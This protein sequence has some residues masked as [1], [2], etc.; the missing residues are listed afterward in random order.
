MN[1]LEK[2]YREVTDMRWISVV[3]IIAALLA[4]CSFAVGQSS[5][6][7]NL[8]EAVE[9]VKYAVIAEVVEVQEFTG[10][11]PWQIVKYKLVESLKG[12]FKEKELKRARKKEDKEKAKEFELVYIQ[13][14]KGSDGYGLPL[15]DEFVKKGEKFVLFFDTFKD[16]DGSEKLRSVTPDPATVELSATKEFLKQV[17]ELL[18]EYEKGEKEREKAL[19]KKSHVN[20][21]PFFKITKAGDDWLIIDLEEVKKKEL[22]VQPTPQAK[23]SVKRYYEGMYCKMFNKKAKAY[24]VIYSKKHETKAKIDDMKKFAE[25]DIKKRFGDN[26]TITSCKKVGIC[27]EPSWAFKYETKTPDGKL[28]MYRERYVTIRK[29]HIFDIWMWCPD[30]FSKEIKK[31]FKEMMKKFRF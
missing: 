29:G 17:K 30:E 9:F 19:K 11:V 28:K 15:P 5:G 22:A 27:R 3:L 16:K 13:S 23:E 14:V 24:M 10:K 31:D 4:V 20:K 1:K 18:K 7:P 2:Y 26:A 6:L 8:K 25:E 21:K 12:D